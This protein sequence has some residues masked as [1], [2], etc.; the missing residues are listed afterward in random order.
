MVLRSR[1]TLGA[2]MI[3]FILSQQSC[4]DYLQLLAESR[5]GTFPQIT[6]DVLSSYEFICPDNIELFARFS[7]RVLEPFTNL[8]SA[9]ELESEEL[10]A[11]RDTLL[12]KLLSGEL[13]IPDE[14]L[15]E[16]AP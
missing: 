2:R 13:E 10:T 1:G 3:Y 8:R 16:A 4:V 7:G 5:S 6:F 12:P 14:L 15:S 9:L 11:L